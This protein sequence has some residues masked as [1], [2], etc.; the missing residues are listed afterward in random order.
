[1]QYK[2]EYQTDDKN[3]ETLTSET[4]RMSVFD[5]CGFDNSQSKSDMSER[6]GEV[7]KYSNVVLLMYSV[8]D[9]SSFSG[10]YSIA[11]IKLYEKR[12]SKTVPC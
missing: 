7:L 1:M 2:Y 11:D 5:L 10:D 12:R 8:D 3:E 6:I 4:L 9:K